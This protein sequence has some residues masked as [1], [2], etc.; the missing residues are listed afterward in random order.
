MKLDRNL[1]DD[2]RG[3]YGLLKIRKI[4][5]IEQRFGTADGTSGAAVHEALKL[6]QSY[7]IIDWGDTIDS[8]FFLIRLRDVYARNALTS[9]AATAWWDDNAEY[10][11]EVR[12]LADRAGIN[13]PNCKKPD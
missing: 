10:A 3:K 9:Y 11:E 8:E 6:L 12:K 4:T 2:G 13:H 5:E 7:G 1:N